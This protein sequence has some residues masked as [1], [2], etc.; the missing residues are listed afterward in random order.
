VAPD[1][2]VLASLG[3]EPGVA[4]A[5][6]DTSLCGRDY[7][8]YGAPISS[9][10]PEA[11]YS[12]VLSPYTWTASEVYNLAGSGHPGVAAVSYGGTFGQLRTAAERVWHRYV[13]AQK[14]KPDVILFPE[15]C[16]V[17]DLG[18]PRAVTA[19]EALA[20]GKQAGSDMDCALC[21]G[22]LEK[23]AGAVFNALAYVAPDEAAC[24]YRQVHVPPAEQGGVTAGEAFRVVNTAWG[25]VGLALGGDLFFPETLACLSQMG[26]D[27]VLAGA[28]SAAGPLSM[29]VRERSKSFD[30]HVVAAHMDRAPLLP[31]G[32][33]AGVTPFAANLG[34]DT[35][36]G[37]GDVSWMVFNCTS[38]S[39]VRLKPA[40]K[41][42]RPE[43]YHA[44][45]KRGR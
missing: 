41:R 30:I 6:L 39:V 1:G 5:E 12:L 17:D 10:R 20:W 36:L 2:K 43:L 34:L 28:R 14:S 37:T 32:G 38:A 4:I 23:E 8:G 40:M 21:F 29:M 26:A 9:R 22:F 7:W 44:L 24:V 19:G 3:D 18:Q 16:L 42:R 45:A 27:I 25:R 35:G 33:D 13:L 31:P 11:Y 15:K